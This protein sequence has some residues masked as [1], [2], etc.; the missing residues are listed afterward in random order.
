MQFETESCSRCGG[1]GHYSYCSAHG[2]I[3]FKC[4]GSG[5]Q[6]SRAGART[7]DRV[8]AAFSELWDTTI[9]QVHP[10]DI[11]WAAAYGLAH[12]WRRVISVGPSASYGITNGQKIPYIEITFARFSFAGEAST[13]IQRWCK[14][15][16]GIIS[17]LERL[18]GVVKDQ[19]REAEPQDMGIPHG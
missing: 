9:D 3:C 4:K 17:Q 12:K 5:K 19:A 16:E 7:K 1:T 6:L 14:V 2:T 18:K 13:K 10:G 11:V 8:Q 15:P